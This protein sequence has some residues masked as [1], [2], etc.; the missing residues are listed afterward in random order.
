MIDEL[1]DKTT[2]HDPYNPERAL[3]GHLQSIYCIKKA[4]PRIPADGS[5]D[6]GIIEILFCISAPQ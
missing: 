5:S 1:S 3:S 4:R 2:P 6:L